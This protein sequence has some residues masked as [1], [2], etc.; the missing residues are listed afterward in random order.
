[1]HKGLVSVIIPTFRRPDKLESAID[2]VLAQTYPDIEVIVVD[3]NNPNTEERSL[4]EQ[5]MLRYKDDI[6]VRYIKHEHNKNGSAARNTGAKNSDAEFIAFLDDDDVF[7][8]KKIETQVSVLSKKDPSWG[9]CYT[10]YV[11]KRQDG[12]VSSYSTERKEG[13][14]YLEALMREFH[15]ASGSNLLVRKEAF[16]SINGFDESF[17]RNQDIEFL[18]RLLKSFKIAYADVL[19]LIVNNHNNHDYYDFQNIT[20]QYLER[21]EC[22]ISQLSKEEKTKFYKSISQQRL[23]D[24]LFTKKSLAK[25]L[26]Q[27]H[28]G[29]SSYGDLL[30]VVWLRF[31][32]GVRGIKNKIMKQSIFNL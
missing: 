23:F 15:I 12:R 16:E 22:F 31:R 17:I 8:P 5:I 20:D 14:L 13:N 4:T 2:S 3:D 9:C 6:R 25:C 24:F 1:M 26:K 7:F 28:K 30:A 32:I 19:G 10:K 18:T 29:D 27:I 21:F 11:V